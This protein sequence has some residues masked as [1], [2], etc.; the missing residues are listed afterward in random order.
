MVLTDAGIGRLDGMT[1]DYYRR[2]AALM[3]DLDDDA[4][5]ALSGMLLRVLANVGQVSAEP[6]VAR[7][8]PA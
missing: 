1:H 8:Q 6:I 3:A 7:K 4:K 2:V 5:R